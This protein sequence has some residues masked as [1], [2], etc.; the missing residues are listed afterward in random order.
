MHAVVP[1]DL[2]HSE[3]FH[4]GLHC[5]PKYHRPVTFHYIIPKG[6]QDNGLD[7][8]FRLRE[9]NKKNEMARVTFLVHS[10]LSPYAA[11]I[12]EVSQYNS[13]WYMRHSPDM[14]LEH[15]QTSLCS[16][17]ISYW[18]HKN[19]ILGA[20]LEGRGTGGLDHAQIQQFSSWGAGSR[21]S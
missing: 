1:D 7:K 19:S 13:K 17:A 18:G 2:T 6:T 21:R 3:I 11:F 8:D 12:C 16:L 4:L 10:T 14:N 20:D 15:A 5:L 9:I